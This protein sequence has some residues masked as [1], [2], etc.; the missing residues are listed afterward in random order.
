VVL[1]D[2]RATRGLFDA[3]TKAEQLTGKDYASALVG[4]PSVVLEV[5][6]LRVE[7]PLTVADR[8]YTIR[9]FVLEGDGALTR[10]FLTVEP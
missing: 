9:D 10:Y 5:P 6:G 8:A 2:G 1:P 4:R 3:A 7:E